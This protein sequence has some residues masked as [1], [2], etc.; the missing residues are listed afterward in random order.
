MELKK[1]IT[2]IIGDSFLGS[3][4][5]G[6][7]KSLYPNCN[8]I[9]LTFGK[10]SLKD[11]KM[12]CKSVGVFDI[13]KIILIK[14]IKNTKQFREFIIELSSCKV[15]KLKIIIWDS[16]EIINIDPKNGISKT[17]RDFFNNCSVNGNF[18]LINNGSD[19]SEKEKTQIEDYV[20]NS[21]SKNM[22]RISK[23]NIELFIEIVGRNKGI[24]SSEINKLCLVAPEEVDKK[25]ILENAFPS[26]KSFI[27]Y[28]MANYLDQSYKASISE[29][30]YLIGIG[31]EPYYIGNLILSKAKWNLAI[32]DLYSK[33]NDWFNVKDIILKIGKFPSSVWNNDQI[34]DSKKK[35]LCDNLKDLENLKEFMVSVWGC[36]EYLFEGDLS[37][38]RADS[39]N[40]SFIAEMMIKSVRDK[41]LK[42]SK[43]K[44]DLVNRFLKIYL[45]CC[46]ELKEIRFGETNPVNCLRNMINPWFS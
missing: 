37:G 13:E 41:Q 7:I 44:S 42:K 46:R 35:K 31:K 1:S 3:K 38:R 18:S 26:S 28:N 43:N 17:W 19:F 11:I 6:E 34:P 29:M 23:K 5:I 25:F 40:S 9:S 2:F 22:R 33:G 10:D 8:W 39:I 14:D 15:D 32:A 12:L 36:P 24:I 16:S 20:R 45:E 4:N 27:F 30:E 21:F